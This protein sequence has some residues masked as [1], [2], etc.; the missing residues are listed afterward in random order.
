MAKKIQKITEE[1]NVPDD[2][3]ENAATPDVM[4]D[5]N[6]VNDD[7]TVAPDLNVV[8]NPSASVSDSTV[9]E[10][11]LEQETTAVANSV[12]LDSDPINRPIE[13][14][15]KKAE[16]A[17]ADRVRVVSPMKLVVKRFFRSKLSVIGLAVFL[18]VLLFS[19]LGPVFV[20][21]GESEVDRSP[22]QRIQYNNISYTANDPND[23]TNEDKKYT[24]YVIDFNHPTAGVE[25]ACACGHIRNKKRRHACVACSRNGQKRVRYISSAYVRRTVVAFVELFGRIDLYRA[26][27]YI[28]RTRRILR[29]VGRHDYNAYSRYTQ[30][31]T[32]FAHTADYRRDIRRIYVHD[33]H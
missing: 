3:V 29:R 11:V 21:W 18:A 12:A 2:I 32:V 9:A 10:A 26:R 20:P 19:F 6:T 22:A 33:G 8:E 17:L 15:Q 27:N 23:P 5:A 13:G 7:N 4:P 1:R 30:L 28:G 31:Y 24:Y 16:E 14:E 25:R